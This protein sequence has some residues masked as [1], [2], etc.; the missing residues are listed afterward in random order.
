M[1]H[2]ATAFWA[3]KNRIYFQADTGVAGTQA[4]VAN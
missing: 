3:D 4:G 1:L 2:I